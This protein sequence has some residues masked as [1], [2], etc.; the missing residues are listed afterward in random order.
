MSETF[1]DPKDFVEQHIWVSLM[2]KQFRRILAEDGHEGEVLDG[3]TIAYL[4]KLVGDPQPP[5]SPDLAEQMERTT[6]LITKM[7]T[8]DEL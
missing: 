2:L 1:P 3:L 4:G 6:A 7:L 8:E 5:I